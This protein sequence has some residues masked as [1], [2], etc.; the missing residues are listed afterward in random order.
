MTVVMSCNEKIVALID[1]VFDKKGC[2]EFIDYPEEYCFFQDLGRLK[3]VALACREARNQ[4][5]VSF[6]PELS[7]LSNKME[8]MAAFNIELHRQEL[9]S[10]AGS[11][12]KDNEASGDGLVRLPVGRHSTDIEAV[13]RE[14]LFGS[15]VQIKDIYEDGFSGD[16][17]LNKKNIYR[18]VHEEGLGEFVSLKGEERDKIFLCVSGECLIRSVELVLK[19]WRRHLAVNVELNG[20]GRVPMSSFWGVESDLYVNHY[21]GVNETIGFILKFIFCV[22]LTWSQLK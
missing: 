7:T 16:F 13:Y 18:V 15:I 1:S 22:N 6:P 20:V 11:L 2:F 3:E 9:I 12:C 21:G 10:W 5:G 17:S 4:G 14:L 19:G 8:K